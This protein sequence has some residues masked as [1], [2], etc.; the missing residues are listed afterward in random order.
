MTRASF[1]M[2]ISA[3]TVREQK[4]KI[5]VTVNNYVTG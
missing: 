2:S 1:I 5:P 4:N 3:A